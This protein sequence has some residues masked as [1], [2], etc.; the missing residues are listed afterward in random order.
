VTVVDVAGPEEGC[1]TGRD[2]MRSLSAEDVA[3]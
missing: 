2:F 3:S 1:L